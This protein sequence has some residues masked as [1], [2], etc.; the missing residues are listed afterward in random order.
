MKQLLL[1]GG[2][3]VA[4]VF[5]F[6]LGKSTSTSVIHQTID[7]SLVINY[8]ADLDIIRQDLIT[9]RK[10]SPETISTVLTSIDEASKKWDIPVGLMHAIFRVESEYN[11]WID[12]PTVTVTVNNKRVTTQAVGMGG[13]IWEFWSDSLKKYDIAQTRTDLYLPKNNINASAAILRWI[14]DNKL[15]NNSTTE[16]NLIN[17]IISG[18][19]GAYDQTYHKKMER[20]TSDLWLKRIARVLLF[21]EK[22]PVISDTTKVTH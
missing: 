12:H 19:Y 15:Q 18:Y 16:Y 22:K 20:I 13:I 4:L 21:K 11:F 3:V 14:T 5:A 6:S 8:E 10:L 17:K 9:Y 2:F 7:T 1:I